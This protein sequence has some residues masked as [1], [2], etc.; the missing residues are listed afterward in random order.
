M[1]ESISRFPLFGPVL[2]LTRD[3]KLGS[4]DLRWLEAVQIA[5]MDAGTTMNDP[6]IG[7]S[8]EPKVAVESSDPVPTVGISKHAPIAPA[9]ALK[10]RNA[11]APKRSGGSPGVPLVLTLTSAVLFLVGIFAPSF[12]MIPKLGNGYF[13]WLV[14]RFVSS[15]LEPRSFSLVSGIIHLFRDGDLFVGGVILLFSVVFPAAKLAT[16]GL[17]FR[18]DGNIAERHL[19]LLEQL[20]K[21]SMLDV[22][23]VAALVVCFKGFPGGSHVQVEWGIY[24]FAGSVVLSMIATRAMR[25]Y[26]VREHNIASH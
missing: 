9:I 17:G 16:L 20:G 1:E 8:S 12:T 3:A 11:E 23:V 25:K 7:S 5:I 13:E 21:W 4:F 26:H 2:F 18:A 10:L 6:S 22:F 19:A 24:V 15:N 14:R